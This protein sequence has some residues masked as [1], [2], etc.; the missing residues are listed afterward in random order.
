[1][2]TFIDYK[3]GD[4][5]RHIII[6]PNGEYR[7]NGGKLHDGFTEYHNKISA[8]GWIKIKEIRR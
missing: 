2:Y 4:E 3:R 6:R 5:T 7:V 8:N 1:M